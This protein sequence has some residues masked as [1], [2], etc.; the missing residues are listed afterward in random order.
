MALVALNIIS[1]MWQFAVAY[2]LM[3]AL[4]IMSIKDVPHLALQLIR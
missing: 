1:S 2:L 4:L 3:V